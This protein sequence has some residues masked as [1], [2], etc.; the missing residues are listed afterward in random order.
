MKQAQSSFSLLEK[1]NLGA[2]GEEVLLGSSTNYLML[3]S[4]LGKAKPTTYSL[5]SVDFTYGRKDLIPNRE[6]AG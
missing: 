2:N 6:T 4:K 1:N 3:R 5:P